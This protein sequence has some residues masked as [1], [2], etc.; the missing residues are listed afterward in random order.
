M[1]K[2]AFIIQR[3]NVLQAD[4]TK[5]MD[6]IGTMNKSSRERRSNEFMISSLTEF[7]LLKVN[8]VFQLIEDIVLFESS[9]RNTKAFTIYM[10]LIDSLSPEFHHRRGS[11]ARLYSQKFFHQQIEHPDEK[12][13]LEH[14]LLAANILIILGKVYEVRE[15]LA[16]RM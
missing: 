6:T 4:I 1:E 7:C 2:S 5:L 9:D 14:N 12:V 13:A 16:G 15:I 10:R 11:I 8:A 3:I